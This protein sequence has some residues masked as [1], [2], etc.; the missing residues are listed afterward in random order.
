M[1]DGG[2]GEFGFQASSERGSGI[3]PHLVLGVEA[4]KGRVL[5]YF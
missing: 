5:E 3:K 1:G 2:G 4:R